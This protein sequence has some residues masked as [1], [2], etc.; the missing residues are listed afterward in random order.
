MAKTIKKAV[1][2]VA[3]KKVAKKSV[4]KAVKKTVVKTVLKPNQKMFELEVALL[5]KLQ[6]ELFDAIAQKPQAMDFDEIR[7]Y[8]DNVY[9]TLNKCVTIS[10]DVKNALLKKDYKDMFTDTYNS[11][12]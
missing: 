8:V 11:P 4:H 5:D 7:L 6:S 1:K 3:P 12:A 9:M 2:K 10:K